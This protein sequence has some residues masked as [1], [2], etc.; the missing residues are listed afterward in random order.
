MISRNKISHYNGMRLTENIIL[1]IIFSGIY[2]FS[3]LTRYLKNNI[4]AQF[5][6]VIFIIPLIFHKSI[7]SIN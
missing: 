3:R 5:E 6:V 7:M 2:L 4:Q 1:F